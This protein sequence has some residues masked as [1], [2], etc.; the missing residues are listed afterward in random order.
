L[1]LPGAR[2]SR[3]E[4]AVT[5][6]AEVPVHPIGNA[7]AEGRRGTSG[8]GQI[9]R[10][11]RAAPRDDCNAPRELLSVHKES[12]AHPTCR[13]LFFFFRAG[14]LARDLGCLRGH[15]FHNYWRVRTTARR[16]RRLLGG[17]SVLSRQRLH[18]HLADARVSGATHGK[19]SFKNR[20]DA[21]RGVSLP[22][23]W[24]L[25]AVGRRILAGLLPKR[26]TCEGDVVE[27]DLLRQQLVG[28][29]PRTGRTSTSYNPRC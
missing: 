8:E 17:R 14:W 7:R 5:K 15:A 20:L 29:S 28:R 26:S 3:Y 10:P 19:V 11:L 12:D 27:S 6:F 23:L 2:G 4:S 18:H 25:L 21:R 22:A 24:L 13:Y 9:I 16:M 1:P